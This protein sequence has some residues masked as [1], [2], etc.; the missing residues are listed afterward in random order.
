MTTAVAVN[1]QEV[2]PTL[3][4][5]C[6]TYRSPV[7]RN[8]RQIPDA[9]LMKQDSL[10]WRTTS[11]C[12]GYCNLSWCARR[13]TENQTRMNSWQERNGSALRNSPRWKR[14]PRASANSPMRNASNS[15]SSK[16]CNAPTCMSW[17]KRGVT[18]PSCSC[19][20]KS[21][22]WKPLPRKSIRLRS[23][24]ADPSCRRGATGLLQREALGRACL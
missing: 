2:I 17:T 7:F 19:N 13:P 10:N 12:T 6:G 18:R 20:P 22:Q 5:Q 14:F 23:L 24:A 9:S 3:Y 4:P 16:T 21:I 15:N 8:R 1:A 11:D